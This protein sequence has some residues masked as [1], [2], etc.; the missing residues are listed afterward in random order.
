MRSPQLPSDY[1]NS[2][3]LNMAIEIVDFPIK[4]GGKMAIEMIYL[5]HEK[6]LFSIVFCMFT[7]GYYIHKVRFME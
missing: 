2:V 3:L 5:P 1:V 6:M 4:N 7:G